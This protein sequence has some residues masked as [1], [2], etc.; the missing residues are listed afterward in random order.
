MVNKVILV[1]RVGNDPE[2]K[3]AGNGNAIA[4]FSLATS[5]KWKD[6]D[7][8][9]QEKTEWHKIVAFGRQA[10]V[11]GEYIKKGSQLYIEGSIQTRSWDDNDGN[12]RYTT[13][14]TLK[15]MEMLGGKS[16]S[17][18]DNSGSGNSGNNKSRPPSPQ[19]Q[20]ASAPQQSDFDDD[21]P[22]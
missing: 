14:I 13:E 10:E 21:I 16:D 1:G 12:K 7:G 20:N 6:K 3:Y 11:I 18:G 17:G 9:K 4:N 8:Q 5:E 19:K 22:F 15:M 2:I